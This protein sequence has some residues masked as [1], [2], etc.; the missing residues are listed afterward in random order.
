MQGH[1][2]MGHDDGRAALGP[3]ELGR[4]MIHLAWTAD[5]KRLYIADSGKTVSVVDVA[6]GKVVR[7]FPVERNRRIA[8]SATKQATR[9]VRMRVASARRARQHD[10][11][12]RCDNGRR[13][14]RIRGSKAGLRSWRSARTARGYSEL[15]LR[16]RL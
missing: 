15:I 11:L 2:A 9:S 7:T 6:A 3:I 16:G 14:A 13:N 5:S 8:L 4:P 1:P 10:P 12:T